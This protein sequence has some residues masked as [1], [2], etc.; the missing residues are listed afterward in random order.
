MERPCML[1]GWPYFQN[2]SA[3]SMQSQ[4]KLRGNIVKI[5]YIMH[6]N[7]IIPLFCIISMKEFLKALDPSWF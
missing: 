6:E 3:D 5:Y 7:P 1:M 4:E 2:Q